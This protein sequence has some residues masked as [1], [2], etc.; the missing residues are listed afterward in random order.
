M[1]ACAHLFIFLF[2]LL[3]ICSFVHWFS[4]SVVQLFS[5]SVVHLFICSF[6][7]L[8]GC[9]VILSLFIHSFIYL[10]INSFHPYFILINWAATNNI[11]LFLCRALP[12]FILWI[13]PLI[14]IL[15][16]VFHVQC[17]MYI[18]LI[19]YILVVL[20]HRLMDTYIWSILR[21]NRFR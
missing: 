4:C 11:F 9:S 16:V 6:V 1:C 7:R 12:I 15:I 21:P 14:F 18:M 5:C 8:F 3:F 20:S 19:W 17:T 2:V 13:S 10:F